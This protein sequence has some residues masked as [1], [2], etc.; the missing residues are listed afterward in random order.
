MKN[1]SLYAPTDISHVAIA[2]VI[3]L[4]T[5]IILPKSIPKT[6]F[7]DPLFILLSRPFSFLSKTS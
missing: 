2:K 6:V 3:K 1:K 4:K 5:V 7:L